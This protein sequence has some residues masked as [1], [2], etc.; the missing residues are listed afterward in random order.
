[1]FYFFVSFI[2]R[3]FVEGVGQP[4]I[5]YLTRPFALNLMKKWKEAGICA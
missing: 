5:I 2:G 1:M 4:K 3:W